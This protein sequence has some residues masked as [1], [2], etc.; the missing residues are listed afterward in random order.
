MY[1]CHQDD[2]VAFW[3]WSGPHTSFGQVAEDGRREPGNFSAVAPEGSHIKRSNEDFNALKLRQSRDGVQNEVVRGSRG[4]A[5]HRI[6]LGHVLRLCAESIH[7]GLI[8]RPI[9]SGQGRGGGLS[10]SARGGPPGPALW[11]RP[12]AR[13]RSTMLAEPASAW[14]GMAFSSSPAANPPRHPSSG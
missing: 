9:M 13:L 10:L 4:P 6:V 5:L 8:E 14:G 2:L 11:R 12:P 7:S 3:L 1:P